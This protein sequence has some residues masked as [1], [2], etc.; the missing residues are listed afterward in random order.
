[1]MRKEFSGF[2]IEQQKDGTIL[3]SQEDGAHGDTSTIEL[4]PDDAEILVKHLQEAIR[5]RETTKTG[6]E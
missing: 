1:M 4:T 2:S 6:T 3:I 5:N